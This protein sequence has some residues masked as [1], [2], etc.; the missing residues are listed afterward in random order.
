MKKILALL[1]CIVLAFGCCA[2]GKKS[3]A[4]AKTETAAP[5]SSEAP[6]AESSPAAPSA[7]PEVK[8]E[9]SAAPSEASK[10]EAGSVKPSEAPAEAEPTEAPEVDLSYQRGVLGDGFYENQSLGIGWS[11]GDNWYFA[12][13]EE[14][15]MLMGSTQQ[16][17][18]DAEVAQTVESGGVF[19]DLFAQNADGYTLNLQVQTFN[20]VFGGAAIEMTDQMVI[21]EV[22]RQ[23]IDDGYG[24]VLFDSLGLTAGDI[25]KGTT[26]FAGTSRPCLYVCGDLGDG[27]PYYECL[28]YVLTNKYMGTLTAASIGE[29]V[30]GSIFNSFYYL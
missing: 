2:C 26:T 8:A 13:E 12:S 24:Q 25:Y 22:Y 17:L 20:S 7:A 15:A 27:V 30:T 4:A 29:D 11:Y 21:D 10:P 1:L 16:T 3:P 28:V 5:A 23:F 14:L 6:K 19:C 9:P 18:S